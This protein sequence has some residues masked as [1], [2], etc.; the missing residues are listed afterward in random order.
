MQDKIVCLHTHPVEE[1]EC[2]HTDLIDVKVCNHVD[3]IVDETQFYCF[4][5]L[6]SFFTKW[7]FLVN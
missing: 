5:L 3:A 2:L 4:S 1:E 7:P 6:L